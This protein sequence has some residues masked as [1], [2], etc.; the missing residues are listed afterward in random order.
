MEQKKTSKL[1][2]CGG[3][4]SQK[5][6]EDLTK[7]N[8]SLHIDKRLAEEDI[9]GSAAYATVLCA[10][11][12]IQPGELEVIQR[13]LQKISEEWTS[14]AIVLRDDDEDVHSLNERRLTELVGDVG[15]KI[16][17]GR[18]RNDQVALDMKLWIKKA[19]DD[20]LHE[21]Q[22]FFCVLIEKAEK[23]IDILMPGYTHLQVGKRHHLSRLF[24]IFPFFSNFSFSERSQF[25]L[26]IGFCRM[27]S[28]LK[29][30]VSD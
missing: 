23:N 13:A 27:A 16:H 11:K 25:D 28:L 3:R 29:P 15:R 17:T 9:R 30:I 12:I 4:F 6:N 5:M 14:G 10:A 24:I 26:V 8:N 21:F 1:W 7:L 20:I 2:G 19:I 18:S 22:T